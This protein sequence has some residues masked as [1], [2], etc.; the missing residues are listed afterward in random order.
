MTPVRNSRPRTISLLL[1]FV[2][3]CIHVAT[4]CN[5]TLHRSQLQHVCRSVAATCSQSHIS[6]TVRCFLV[7][8]R[9]VVRRRSMY[10]E[11]LQFTS[12]HEKVFY[13]IYF[14]TNQACLS[15]ALQV[16]AA[17]MC[18]SCRYLRV[19]LRWR[20]AVSCYVYTMVLNG[21]LGGDI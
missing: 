2:K 8:I 3:P 1:R 15:V 12:T 14:F 13:I 4:D 6:D 11:E 21:V 18:S 16:I 5:A 17:C 19:N 9:R 7:T 10:A 20:I